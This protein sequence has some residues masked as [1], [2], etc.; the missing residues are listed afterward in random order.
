MF[1]ALKTLGVPAKLCLFRGES[2]ELSR[3]GKPWNREGRL[4]EILGWFQKYLNDDH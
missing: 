2:H 4:N 1:N 3:S